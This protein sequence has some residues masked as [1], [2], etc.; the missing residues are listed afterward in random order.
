MCLSYRCLSLSS[1]HVVYLSSVFLFGSVGI[2]MCRVRLL[3]CGGP[4][5]ACPV[6]PPF[7]LNSKL[8]TTITLTLPHAS[9][10]DPLHI[11]SFYIVF[12][13]YIRIREDVLPSPE[14]ACRDPPPPTPSLPVS[15]PLNCRKERKKR[16][17]RLSHSLL[18]ASAAKPHESCH[19]TC[20]F[21]RFIAFKFWLLSMICFV[22]LRVVIFITSL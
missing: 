3:Q 6:P 11:Y 15:S 4:L 10:L 7:Y 12:L 9:N 22:C 1:L 14:L 18:T 5:S 20:I 21:L 2:F 17:K 16:I 8:L 19:S 13:P